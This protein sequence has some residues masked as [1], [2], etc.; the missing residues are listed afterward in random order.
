MAT[1]FRATWASSQVSTPRPGPTS[2]TPAQSEAPL[3][4]AMRGHTPGLMRKFWPRAL[5][6]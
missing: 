1:T 4:W 6:K 5:E 3:S 2:I